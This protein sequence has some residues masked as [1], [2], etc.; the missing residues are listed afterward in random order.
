MYSIR[1]FLLKVFLFSV[2]QVFGQLSAE[3]LEQAVQ[4]QQCDKIALE[5]AKTPLNGE[6]MKFNGA[7]CLYRNGEVEKAMSLFQE[8]RQMEAQKQGLATFWVSKCYAS[9]G[10]DSMAVAILSS[11]PAGI[12]NYRMLSQKEFDRLVKQNPVFNELKASL[13]PHFDIWTTLLGA[14]SALGMLLGLL[15]LFG[16]SHF[17]AGEGWLSLTMLSFGLILASYVLI[18]TGYALVFPYL[19]NIWQCLTLVVG[20]SLFFYLK[21]TFKEEY[22]TRGIVVHFTIPALS[23]LF[24]IPEYLKNYGIN[25]SISSDLFV[26]GT[27]PV[28]LTGHLIYYSILIHLLSKNEWQVDNN[29]VVLT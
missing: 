10:N 12:L 18:W 28:L 24:T 22:T 19:Q 23:C 1:W 13:A 17:S 6:G 8:V 29:R 14:V 5:L 11:I 25:T 4:L 3:S 7:V 20:P 15:L 27:A 26:I 21:A 16:K 2:G 9:L